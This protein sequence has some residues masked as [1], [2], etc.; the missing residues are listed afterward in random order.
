VLSERVRQLGGHPNQGTGIGGMMANA[1]AAINS[2]ISPERL[3]KQV[4]SGE[5]KGIHA[6][7]DRID[8]LDPESQN[9][10]QNIMEEDHDH[11][12]LFKKRMESEKREYDK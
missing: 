4:Y 7:E 1:A 5:D 2:M 8:E 11:L 3:L 6:Y 9:L 10:V 12:R